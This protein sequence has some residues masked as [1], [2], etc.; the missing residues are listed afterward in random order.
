MARRAVH[1]PSFYDIA[2]GTVQRLADEL[3]VERIAAEYYDG[4]DVA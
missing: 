3:R 2:G 4:G 1:D